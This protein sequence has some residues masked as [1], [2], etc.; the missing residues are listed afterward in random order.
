MCLKMRRC[1][2]KVIPS[3]VS[4]RR[5]SEIRLIDKMK[6]NCQVFKAE[7]SVVHLNR[8]VAHLKNALQ[9]RC[10]KVIMISVGSTPHAEGWKR[11][12]SIGN[13]VQIVYLQHQVKRVHHWFFSIV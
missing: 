11:L 3:D 10:D 5:R 13:M 2:A 1:H 6:L 4:A 12:T 7:I 9:D 8:Q